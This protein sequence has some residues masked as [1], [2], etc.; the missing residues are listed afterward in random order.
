MSD[1]TLYSKNKG[2]RE[3][4]TF[5]HEIYLVIQEKENIVLFSACSHK[6]IDNII[7]TI[8]KDNQIKFTH[9]LGGFHFIRYNEDIKE[10]T[11]FITSLG[12]KFKNTDTTYF[13][14]HCTG[15]TAF[16]LLN[17]TMDNLKSL[18]TGDVV[19]ID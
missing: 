11:D 15:D 4:D 3:I 18:H 12:K 2:K 9:V 19:V 13:A 5:H 10:Q 17:D 8:E 1:K 7:T 14:C 16:H 6:G